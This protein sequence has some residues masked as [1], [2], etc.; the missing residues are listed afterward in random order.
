MSRLQYTGERAIPGLTPYFTMMEHIARYRLAQGLAT[1]KR[2]LDACCGLGYGTAMM[3]ETAREAIG[4]DVDGEAIAHAREEFASD[5]ANAGLNEEDV[6]Y[7]RKHFASFRVWFEQCDIFE[8]QGGDFD[9]VVA[10]EALEHVEDGERFVEILAQSLGNQGMVLVSI[11]LPGNCWQSPFHVRCFER[12][13][14]EALMHRQFSGWI[15]GQ[16]GN[17]IH[18]NVA[19]PDYW[20]FVGRK[21]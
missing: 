11:P 1:H 9:L 15:W 8:W 2:V 7:A 16:Q 17:E 5:W 6:A 3:A 18:A 4:F 13:G 19:D 12:D 14:F 10:L 20:V 21:R